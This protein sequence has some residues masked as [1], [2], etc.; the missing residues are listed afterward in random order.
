MGNAPTN[1]HL[2]R[3]GSVLCNTQVGLSGIVSHAISAGDATWSVSDET[4]PEFLR[5]A[6]VTK[7][8]RVECL[9]P[10]TVESRYRFDFNISSIPRTVSTIHCIFRW[11]DNATSPAGFVQLLY[12]HNNSFA[13]YWTYNFNPVQKGRW[14]FLAIPRHLPQAT[15]GT[16]DPN[17]TFTYARVNVVFAAGDI[18]E[19]YLC[20]LF[21][22]WYGKPHISFVFDDVYAEDYS[23]AF[24][25]M[26]ARN[27]VGSL[28]LSS[29]FVDTSMFGIPRCTTP[30]IREMYAAGWSMHNHTHTHPFLDAMTE[31]QIRSEIVRCRDWIQDNGLF[32]RDTGFITPFGAT[33]SLVEKVI[34][35]YYPTQGRIGGDAQGVALWDSIPNPMWVDRISIDQP[36]LLSTRLQDLDNAI[37]R[38]HSIVFYG[39][40]PMAAAGAGFVELATLQGLVDRAKLY[41][42]AGLARIVNYSELFT[43]MKLSRGIR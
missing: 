26:A 40:R 32:S 30:Q 19:V 20:P 12:A 35:D 9:T 25:Y 23:N 38:G 3:S 21:T 11:P 16:P 14:Q 2:I 37:Q 28:A 18:G 24:A 10:G 6:G 39:H 31:D 8:F 1:G 41:H 5:P 15:T 4:R 13:N 22:N 29:G 43:R 17:N 27:V 34:A 33:N 36:N 7:A 42:D